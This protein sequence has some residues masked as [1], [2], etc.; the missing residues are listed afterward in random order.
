MKKFTLFSALTILLTSCV[1]G[2]SSDG[3]S[4]FCRTGSIFPTTRNNQSNYSKEIYMHRGT[5]NCDPCEP[6]HP[7]SPCEPVCNPCDNTTCIG[8]GT[9]MPITKPQ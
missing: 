1:I 3:I 7:C 6:V 9:P 2:C 5:N 4:S 8:P